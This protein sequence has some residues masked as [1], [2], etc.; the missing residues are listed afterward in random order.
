MNQTVLVLFLA[1]A[2][3]ACKGKK[4]KPEIPATNFFPAPSY[5]RAELKH[6]DTARLSFTKIETVNGHADTMSV[7]NTD[8]RLYAKDFLA[9][10]DI[11]SSELKDDY[12]VSHLYDDLQDAFVFNFITKESHPLREENIT[13]DPQPNAAGKNDIK[14]IYAKLEQDS[15]NISVTKILLW[16]AGKGFYTTTIFDAPDKTEQIKKVQIVWNGFESG[17]K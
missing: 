9:L 8:V 13:V 16:E 12:E 4:K 3:V 1:L 6:L 10:P 11:A 5:I 14:S 7:K 17:N 15:A 2:L